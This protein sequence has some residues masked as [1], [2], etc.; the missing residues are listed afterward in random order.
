MHYCN[1][2]NTLFADT[3]HYCTPHKYTLC[4]NTTHYTAPH[5]HRHTL[6]R[7]IN[8]QY[9]LCKHAV[10]LTYIQYT[11]YTQY[12]TVHPCNKPHADTWCITGHPTIQPVQSRSALQCNPQT[13]NTS[14]ADM[15]TTVHPINTKHTLDRHAVCLTNIQYSLCRHPVHSTN[16]ACADM[17]SSTQTYNTPCADTQCIPY[18]HYVY[19]QIC[20]VPHKYPVQPVQTHSALQCIPQILDD[21]RFY[22]VLFSALKQT[23]CAHMW[24]YMSD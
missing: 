18:I 9:I 16:T 3:M 13:H 10:Y 5:K 15:C 2:T 21:D 11:L 12:T 23:H 6:C 4:R 14:C 1:L 7:H 22:I 19:V 17:Q 20:D 8:T 24:C